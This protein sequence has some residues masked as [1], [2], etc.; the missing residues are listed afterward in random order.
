MYLHKLHVHV[1]TLVHE[2]YVY[3]YLGL[4]KPQLSAAGPPVFLHDDDE[5]FSYQKNTIKQ[6]FANGILKALTFLKQ[7][8]I[9]QCRHTRSSDKNSKQHQLTIIC[10]VR[11]K[12]LG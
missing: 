7:Q 4:T 5:Q 9:Q 8:S 11:T 10:T 3:F 1:Y 12:I 2:Q 6:L